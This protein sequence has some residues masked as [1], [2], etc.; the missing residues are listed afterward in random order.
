MKKKYPLSSGDLLINTM[1]LIKEFFDVNLYGSADGDN[2]NN[3]FT[4]MEGLG[5]V[6]DVL[7][8]T[9]HTSA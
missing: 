7:D 8:S 1:D 9:F 5:I 3:E 4:G 2:F 6:D